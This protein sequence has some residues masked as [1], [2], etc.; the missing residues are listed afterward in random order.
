MFCSLY[1]SCICLSTMTMSTI[2]LL[3]Q[4][5]HWLSGVFSCAFVG[6]SL[7]SKTRAKILPAMES[8]VMPRQFVQPDFFSLVFVQIDNDCIPEVLR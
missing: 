2:P 5:P 3:D 6:M 7:F 1:F 8:G 4:N